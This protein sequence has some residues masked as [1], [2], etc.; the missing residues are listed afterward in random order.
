MT[1]KIGLVLSGGS[2]YGFAHIGVIKVLEEN[3]INVDI[4]GGTSM[5]SIVGGL[6]S[7]GV[8]VQQME[9]ILTKFSRKKIVDINPFSFADDGLLYGKKVTKFI[10]DIIGDK[11]IEDCGKEYYCIAS[12]LVNGKKIVLDKGPLTMAI[13]ASM[14]IPGIYK[15][16]RHN[17]MILV[18]GGSSDNLPIQDAR[19]RGADIVIGVDVCSFYQKQNDLKSAFDI[20]ISACN[21]LTSNLVQ[22]QQ[23]KG[24][25]YIKIDQP[26]VSFAKF[27]AE[28]A[29]NSIKNGEEATRKMLPEILEKIKG[30]K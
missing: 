7:A 20:L 26:N 5:G 8:P 23:D 27:T 14:S 30:I 24:D 28:D 1:K 25:I 2:A 6:Y 4:V 17:K 19:Q 9:E 12:D 3:G 10:K 13:R 11:N 15:P 21:L 18:D 29:I 16:I 22:S